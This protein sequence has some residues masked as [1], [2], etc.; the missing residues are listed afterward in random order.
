MSVIEEN[1]LDRRIGREG[2][3][4]THVRNAFSIVNRRR[5]ELADTSGSGNGRTA[6]PK[7]LTAER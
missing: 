6:Q 5:E 1:L 3:G 4:A 7:P 2:W